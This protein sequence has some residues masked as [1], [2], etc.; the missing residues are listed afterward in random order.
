MAPFGFGKSEEEKQADALAEQRAAAAMAA[1][2]RGGIP[3]EA[4]R[5]LNELRSAGGLFTSTLSVNEAA[6]LREL[7]VRPLTQVMGSSVYHVGWQRNW[8]RSWGRGS[9]KHLDVLSHAHND[10]RLRALSR[11]DQEGAL[12]GAH[13]VV[14][15]KVQSGSY[16]WASDAIEFVA[17]GT[18]V[19]I[20]GEPVPPRPALSTLSGDDFWKL[21]LAGHHPVGVAGGSSI[22]YVI[23][24]MDTQR[25][26]QGGRFFGGQRNQ[27]IPDFTQ[28]LYYA[29]ADA[30]Q[31]FQA[32]AAAFG[33]HGVV[34]VQFIQRPRIRVVEVGES[35]RID[36]MASVTVMGTAVIPLPRDS[37][38]D[39]KTVVDVSERRQ[40]VHIRGV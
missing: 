23:P 12:A 35:E 17:T 32:E 11:L 26:V 13:A 25:L 10:A 31:R 37:R 28:G 4:E 22:W 33:C 27:E 21:R 40:N 7:N 34:G 15:V 8:L 18:A 14:G 30:M 3:P 29:R 16:D 19:A 24:S 38:F 2:E 9:I 39:P 5:R 6:R 1:I 36:F 20:E